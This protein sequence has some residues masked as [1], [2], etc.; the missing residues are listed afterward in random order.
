M[1][2]AIGSQSRQQYDLPTAITFL[3]AGVG[4]GSF[5]AILLAPRSESSSRVMTGIDSG[6]AL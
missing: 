1:R 2:F 4:I 6:S 5:L 3:L